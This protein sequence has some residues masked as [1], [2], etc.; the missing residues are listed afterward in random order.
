MGELSLQNLPVELFDHLS[1]YL[2][3]EDLALLSLVS[4][5]LHYILE[6]QLYR[7]ISICVDT[8]NGRLRKLS[9]RV[10]YKPYLAKLVRQLSIDVLEIS[11]ND[12]VSGFGFLRY[13]EALE[14]FELYVRDYDDDGSNNRFIFNSVFGLDYLELFKQRVYPLSALK[15]CE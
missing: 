3:N 12:L 10:S 13:L 8:R 4:K 15:S 9:G 1:V 5:R 7:D 14:H 11:G 6:R 2:D